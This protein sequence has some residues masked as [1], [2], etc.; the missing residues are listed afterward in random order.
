MSK[1]IV[2]NSTYSTDIREIECAINNFSDNQDYLVKGSRNSIK[3]LRLENGE[4]CTIKAFKI[5]NFINKIVY[6]FFRESKAK[7][8]Y[9]HAKILIEKGFKTPTPIAYVEN[10][11]AIT[12]LDSYYFC[13]FIREDFTYRE[14]VHT[15]NFPD[16]ENV[17]RQFTQFTFALHQAGIE[18]LDHSPGNTLIFDKKDGTYE[19]YLVDLNRMKFHDSMTLEQRINNF[20]RLTP[21]RESVEI[22]AK[23]YARLMQLP[24]AEVIDKMWAGT[25]KFQ[26]KFH[27]KQ[28][29]KKRLKKLIGK[30]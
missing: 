24:P 12:F 18:F 6:R 1:E 30:E 4:I 8:S 17:L 26:Q 28:A 27:L 2:V 14:V 7:R 25:E 10:K 16:M 13:A 15:P 21:H 11:T 19:F 3:K 5:P 22:M 20:V 9:R 29:R 23:E